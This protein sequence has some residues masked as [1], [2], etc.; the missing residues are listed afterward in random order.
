METLGIFR[1]DHNLTYVYLYMYVI[2]FKIPI[3]EHSESNELN[4][5]IL[6]IY[7][8][9]ANNNLSDWIQLGDTYL[10]QQVPQR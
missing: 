2:R 1:G 5:T 9:P 6:N 3:E 10:R 7:K 4:D 8:L